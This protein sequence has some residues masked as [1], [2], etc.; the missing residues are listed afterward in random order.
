M[1][2]ESG[3]RMAGR[4]RIGPYKPLDVRTSAIEGGGYIEVDASADRFA[5]SPLAELGRAWPKARS[6]PQRRCPNSSRATTTRR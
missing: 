1:P 2:V 5:V 6:L 4:I 3:A